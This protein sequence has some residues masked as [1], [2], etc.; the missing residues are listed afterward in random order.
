MII[1]R[2][3]GGLG[4]QLQQYSLYEKMRLTGH[5]VRLD[6]SWFREG[7]QKDVL[8]KRKIELDHFANIEYKIAE[9]TDIERLRGSD[10]VMVRGIR[11]ITGINL[12]GRK[13]R[14]MEN[15]RQYCPEIFEMDDAYLE[16]YWACEMYYH[17]ILPAL[18]DKI[19][20]EDSLE[21]RQQRLI[22]MRNRERDDD[23][24]S[25]EEGESV[26]IHIRRGDYLDSA[27]LDEYKNICTPKYYD[28]AEK[29][30]REFVKNPHFYIF[31][32][33]TEYAREH[34]KGN[35]YTVVDV[36]HGDDSYKDIG[37]MSACRHH[38]SANSTFSFWGSRLG[39]NADKI[40]IRPS[41]QRNSQVCVPENMHVWW[42][43]WVLINPE[44][45]II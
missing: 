30:I 35:E 1:I 22:D 14:F 13:H 26:S 29:Y 44:G 16:G 18:R 17:D 32:D 27:N 39:T 23:L 43:D 19:S 28:T 38:I 9:K 15:G 20:F 31:S 12:F 36:N 8:A 25:I 10:S 45:E 37:L 4:N 7:A 33:D 24:N 5:D 11:K 41:I 42:K 3:M 34:Y 6:T 2:L 40:Q 21:T